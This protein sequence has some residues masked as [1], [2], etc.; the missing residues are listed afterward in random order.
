MTDCGHL[1]II[2]EL[3]GEVL[4]G[5][6]RIA[7]LEATVEALLK[8][9]EGLE[10]RVN[11]SSRNSSTPPSAD[12]PHAPGPSP[13]KSS[14]RKPGGQPGHPGHHRAKRDPDNVV[15]HFP[16]VCGGCGGP[17]SED[18]DIGEAV[19]HQVEE[20][21]PI[22]PI[23]TEH[24]CGLRRC[25]RCGKKTRA[26]LPAGVPGWNFGPRVMTAV[27]VLS[28]KFRLTRR[29]LPKVLSD[30]FGLTISVGTIQ[31]LNERVSEVMAGPTEA[32]AEVVHSA[33]VVNADETGCPHRGKKSWLWVATCPRVRRSSA[34]IVGGA[35]RGLRPSCPTT[36]TGC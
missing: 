5:R 22:R 35:P 6:A 29:E 30:F 16:E 17:L 14:G 9:I 20:L 1:P 23:V 26:K 21:P 33:P 12:P 7:E 10:A 8:K 3:R 27:A 13:K 4:A 24:R 34:F 28:S 15:L 25:R 19:C 36:T 31:K 32:I 11:R 2:A 18:D